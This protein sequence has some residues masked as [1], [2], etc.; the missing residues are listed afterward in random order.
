MAK[1]TYVLCALTSVGCAILLIRGYMR[2]KARLL[3]WTSLAFCGFALNNL[4][5]VVDKSTPT[6]D[7]SLERA[8]P[9]YIGMMLLV[10]GLVWES[11]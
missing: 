5:L 2:S 11:K 4:L 6:I 7:L 3:L 1:F 10:F 8:L 9:A